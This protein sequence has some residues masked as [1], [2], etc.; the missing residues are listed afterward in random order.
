MEDGRPS[1]RRLV[2]ELHVQIA[3]RCDPVA[4]AAKIVVEL[5]PPA[6]CKPDTEA[7]ERDPHLVRALGIRARTSDW[8]VSFEMLNPSVGR[9]PVLRGKAPALH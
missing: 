2:L 8:D 3:D 9:D 6:E 4:Q 7:S 1:R 5:L